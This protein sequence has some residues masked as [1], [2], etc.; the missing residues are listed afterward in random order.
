MKAGFF[1]LAGCALLGGCATRVPQA[2]QP[3]MTPAAAM[4]RPI[5]Q[6]IAGPI[7]QTNETA[8]TN[9]PAPQLALLMRQTN[10][11]DLA[12]R[13]IR[14]T[15]GVARPGF[16]PLGPNTS[17][18]LGALWAAEPL[19]ANWHADSILEIHR[20]SGSVEIYRYRKIARTNDPSI[21]PNDHIH[22]PRKSAV[23]W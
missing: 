1:M 22:V 12:K 5:P 13:Y 9:L 23:D 4:P 3:I 7:R 18:L 21:Y 10:E 19:V 6:T 8:R 15:G 16:Y 14:I 11:V 2:P 17:T 20:E